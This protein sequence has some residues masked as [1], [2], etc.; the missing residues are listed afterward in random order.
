MSF[1][2]SGLTQGTQYFFRVTGGSIDGSILSFTTTSASVTTSA[3]TSVV[4][5]S[6][7]LNG[8]V[9]ANGA[10]TAVSFC[11]G[12]SPTLAGCTLVTASPSS[13]TG[14]A[15][16]AVAY[17]LTGLK[18]GT[19]YYFRVSG[20]SGGVTTDGSILTFTTTT[21]APSVPTNV[22]ATP[23]LNQV[24]VSWGAP[25]DDGGSAITAY[26]VRRSTTGTGNWT[27]LVTTNGTTFAYA[28]TG[29]ATNTKYYYDVR[30]TNAL[31]SSTT[32]VV[33]PAG[34]Q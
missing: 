19:A 9:N 30:A 20:I 14:T 10:S 4:G 2:L 33:G 27:N 12:T 34:R 17:S 18:K 8:S 21:S 1:A 22:T 24:V 26:R 7:T 31:G 5:T 29:L 3:A 13:V 32:V 6:A 28:N 11:W 23:G 25:T 16:T 15:D